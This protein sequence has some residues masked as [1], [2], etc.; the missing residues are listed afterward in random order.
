MAS[1]YHNTNFNPTELK[2]N[3]KKLC[4]L[5]SELDLDFDV[6]A[7]TGISGAAISFAVSAIGGYQLACVRRH[8]DKS[9]HGRRVECGLKAVRKYIIV[10]DLIASGNTMHHIKERMEYEYPGIE[11]TGIVLTC[12]DSCNPESFYDVKVYPLY[13][14][15][16]NQVKREG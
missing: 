12:P 9:N 14:T 1:S 7:F 13:K 8:D 4:K 2:R 5:L 3:A 16:A 11:L 6:I 10:D 15:E